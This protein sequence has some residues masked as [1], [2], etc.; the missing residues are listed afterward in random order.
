MFNVND[1]D[2]KIIKNR[3]SILIPVFNREKYIAECIESALSQTYKNIEIIIFDNKSTDTTWEICKK[4][5]E[6]DSRIKIF[7]NDVNCGPVLNWMKCVNEASGEF[8]KILFSDDMLEKNCIE[9]MIIPFSEG[10]VGLTYCA[11]AIGGSRKNSVINY[12]KRGDTKILGYKYINLVLSNLAPVSPGAILLRT[13]DLRKNL[14]LKFP[15]K[16]KRD[17]Q[18][19]GAGPDVM[20]SILTSKSYEFVVA[21]KEVLVFFRAHE[22]SFSV[23]NKENEIENSY[24]SAIAY[25]LKLNHSNTRWML[26]LVNRWAIKILKYYQFVSIRDYLVKNE[27]SGNIFEAIYFIFLIPICSTKILITTAL[28]KNYRNYIR[29]KLLQFVKNYKN[30][31]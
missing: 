16:T 31:Q 25:Y 7:Q 4:Y 3:V 9:K 23:I 20:I 29:R 15:T 5:Q 12:L 21:I 10:D 6:R 14:F 22:E 11:A 1:V 8:S 30:S 27:G 24:I 13:S 28:N 26:Y 2:A 18:N 19:H 17:F